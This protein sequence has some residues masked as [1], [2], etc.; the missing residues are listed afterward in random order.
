MKHNN[1]KHWLPTIASLAFALILIGVYF[2]LF[3]WPASTLQQDVLAEKK[4]LESQ[5]DSLQA[6]V[7]ALPSNDQVNDIEDSEEALLEEQWPSDTWDLHFTRLINDIEHE[8]QVIF[9][10]ISY[11]GTSVNTEGDVTDSGIVVNQFG[12][13]LLLEGTLPQINATL[14]HLYELPN[15]FTVTNWD[16]SPESTTVSDGPIDEQHFNMRLQGHVQLVH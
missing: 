1:H 15:T 7:A 8:F 11:Q 3:T 12:V 9:S 14:D 4:E 10:D 5:L 13:S 16:L 2:F 6:R